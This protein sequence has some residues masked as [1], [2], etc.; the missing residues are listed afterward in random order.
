MAIEREYPPEYRDC[1]AWMHEWQ[2]HLDD[3]LEDHEG[4]VHEAPMWGYPVWWSCNRCDTIKLTVYSKAGFVVDTRYF[5][6]RGYAAPGT[7]KAD[8][9]VMALKGLKRRYGGPKPR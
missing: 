7:Q 5:Y 2:M 8:F 9:R 6:P 4:R 1:R 3:E